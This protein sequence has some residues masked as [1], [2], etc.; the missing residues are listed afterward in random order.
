[1]S[2][3]KCPRCGATMRHIAINYLGRDG[4]GHRY[5]C[6][7]CGYSEHVGPGR[8]SKPSDAKGLALAV[9][10]PVSRFGASWLDDGEED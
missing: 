9:G 3:G 7:G 8:G 5:E 2:D 1:M 10:E 6:P 4:N